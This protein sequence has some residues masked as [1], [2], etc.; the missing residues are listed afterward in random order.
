MRV[1]TGNTA[2]HTRQEMEN[3]AFC[4]GRHSHE[5]CR[6][7]KDVGVRKSILVKF[8]RCFK[9]LQKGHRARDCKLSE[10]CKSC[11]QSRHISICE[12][13]VRPVVNEFEVVSDVNPTSSSPRIFHVGAGGRVALQTACAAITGEGEPQKVRVL[14]D[15][16]SHCSFVTARVAQLV[17]LPMSRQ[18]LLAVSTFGQSS[19]DV[20]LRDVVHVKVSALEGEKVFNVKAYVVPEISTIQNK[21]VEY[22]KFDY[23]HLKRLWF[24]DVS[25]R[26][27]EM[28]I[29]VLIGADYLWNFQKGCTIRGKCDEPVAMETE[30]DW[31]LSGPMKGRDTCSDSH[32]AQVNFI[33]SSLEKQESLKDVHRLWDLETLGIRDTEDEVHETFKNSISF[34]GIRYSVRLPWKE[35]HPELPS[36]YSTSLNHLRTQVRKLERDPEILREY[37]AIIE[38]QLQSGIIEE[39]IELERAPKVDY[40]P[41]QAVV[42]KESATTKVRVVYDASSREGKDEACLNDC[43]HVGPPLTPVLYNI[44]LQFR[45]NRVILVGDGEK[46]FFNVEVDKQDR[47]CLHFLWVANPP[48]LSQV[49]VYRFCQVVFGLNASPFLLNA[50][51]RHD[52]KKYEDCDPSFVSRLLDSFYVDDFVGARRTSE[53]VMELYQKVQSRMAQGAFK[54]RKWLTND[55][56]VRDEIETDTPLEN[57]QVPVSEEDTTYPLFWIRNRGEWKQ[58][59]KH[60]VNEILKMSGKGDWR[61]CP[62]QQNPADIGLRGMT[63]LDLKQSVLWWKDPSWLVESEDNWPT[64]D[65]IVPTTQSQAEEKKASV[66]VLQADLSPG[67]A[68]IVEIANYSCVHTLLRVTAWIKRFCFNAGKRTK[69]EREC[70]PLSLNELAQVEVDWI[71]IVQSELKQQGNYDNNNNNTLF[72]LVQA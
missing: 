34:N 17:Q 37:A 54:L 27:D 50:T 30:P 20:K 31:V 10:L 13:Q 1:A 67:L 23:P 45:E 39:V 42:W 6:K 68:S 64:E 38:D 60:R 41:H 3:C 57:K 51:L 46:A 52:I 8:A 7:V 22:A 33:S 58:F 70:G 5:N 9:C 47:D 21:H 71:K 19:R 12:K 35:G 56:Q 18:D 55:A 24:S 65:L 61:Y 49:V 32:L 26:R 44:L 72:T 66:M 2:L 15:A 48:D 62:S 25:K 40:L 29:N 11:G 69:S 59:V 53:E 63:A 28:V 43:L 4:L 36:N 16:G 14:F